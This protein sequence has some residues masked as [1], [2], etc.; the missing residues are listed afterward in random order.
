MMVSGY[1]KV[2]NR[3]SHFLINILS[4]FKGIYEDEVEVSKYPQLTRE[5]LVD[6]ARMCGFKLVENVSIIINEICPN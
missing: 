4:L 3:K 1:I 6:V 5:G 2:S